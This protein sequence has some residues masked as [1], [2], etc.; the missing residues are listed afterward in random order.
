MSTVYRHPVDLVK[1]FH[2]TYGQPVRDVP[3]FDVAEKPMRHS[4]IDEEVGEFIDACMA[5]DFVEVIDALADIV[6]VVCGAAITHGVALSVS[7]PRPVFLP[8]PPAEYVFDTNLG[9][10]LA[11]INIA[12]HLADNTDELKKHW[13][14]MILACYDFAFA[15]GIDLDEVL[16]EVQASNLS[17]L[18]ANGEVLRR[19]DGKILKGP[20]F[21]VPN[22]A[23]F[24]ERRTAEGFIEL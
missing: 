9:N 18:G 14:E 20:N 11:A 22:I 12:I 7:I 13:E 19:E 17:K 23:K 16:T 10:K 15:F 24:I 3:Q 5:H 8:A 1:E 2:L 21:F 6:Y 4:L